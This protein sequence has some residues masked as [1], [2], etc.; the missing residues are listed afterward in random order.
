M[1]NIIN[2]HM[3]G[4]RLKESREKCKLTQAEVAEI[5]GIHTNSYGN[6]ER[7]TER[8]SLTKIIQCSIIFH[9]QPGDLLN[10][11]APGLLIQDL[12]PQ[13]SQKKELQ[14][15]IILLSKYPDDVIHKLYI[16][17]KAVQDD[18]HKRG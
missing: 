16:G 12:P 6:F 13:E 17:L 2:L 7:G 14:E 4:K 11:C 10:G 5:L 18:S 9:I 3:I 1:D 8:P 15:L